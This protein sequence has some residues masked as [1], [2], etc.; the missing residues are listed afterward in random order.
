M[1]SYLKK[2]LSENKFTYEGKD[3]E[4]S[5]GIPIEEVEMI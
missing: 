1:N 4:L 5:D 2:V 3:V